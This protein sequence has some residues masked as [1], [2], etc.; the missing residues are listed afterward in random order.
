MIDTIFIIIFVILNNRSYNLLYCILDYDDNIIFYPYVS[1]LSFL[2]IYPINFELAKE[3]CKENGPIF[4]KTSIGKKKIRII[5]FGGRS[6]LYLIF[7]GQ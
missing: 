7:V 5:N 1:Y 6:D 4:I 3:I 2:I